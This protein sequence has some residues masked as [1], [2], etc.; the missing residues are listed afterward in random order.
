MVVYSKVIAEVYRCNRNTLCLD[1]LSASQEEQASILI[2]QMLTIILSEQKDDGSWSSKQQTICAL[3]ALVLIFSLPFVRTMTEEIQRVIDKGREALAAMLPNSQEV[4]PELTDVTRETDSD[5]W[6]DIAMCGA[7]FAIRDETPETKAAIKRQTQKILGFVSFFSSRNHLCKQPLWKIKASIIEALLYRPMLQAARKEVFPATTAK[8]KDKY[9]DYIPIMWVLANNCSGESVC[10]TTPEYLLDMM[11]L[12]MYVF[13]VD[14]YMESNIIHFSKFEFAT[15]KRSI[16]DT[17]FGIVQPTSV[18]NDSH[19]PP[20]LADMTPRVH[21]ALRVFRAFTTYIQSYPRI[22]PASPTSL[23]DLRSE[24]QSYLLH[25][26]DQLEDNARLA[27]QPA[28]SS[29][30]EP[31]VFLT[32]RTTY[33]NWLHTTGAG[34]VSGPWSFAFFCCIMSSKIRHGLDCFR[35][36]KQRLLAYKMNDHIGAFCRIYNDYGS[37]D[38]DR[39][40]GNLNSVNFP[41]FHYRTDRG[42]SQGEGEGEM[43]GMERVKKVLLEAAGYE[44]RCALGAAEELYREL[45]GEGEEGRRVVECLRV[46]MGACEQFSDMYITRDV[47]NSVK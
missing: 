14:E 39:E 6:S 1:L 27:Q 23:L 22:T 5:T 20:D 32:P 21:S 25:H 18:T 36:V 7:P 12:S 11:V 37:V 42:W 16:E 19:N 2:V 30:R 3:H 35:T 33:A 29:P 47:T 8:E 43:E 38:R 4:P 26:L 46:Y 9:L 15:L 31:I 13:L 17:G 24:T 28:P 45:E 40:E 34:H 10:R 41:E 44:R